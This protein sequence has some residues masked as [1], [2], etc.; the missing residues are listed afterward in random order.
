MR[1]RGLI[2]YFVVHQKLYRL[3]YMHHC[4]QF[5]LEPLAQ[6]YKDGGFH[7]TVEGV[8]EHFIPAVALVV[9]DAKEVSVIL[10]FSC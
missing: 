5:L 6:C 9:G 8:L 3:Q 7:M 4:I 10:A 2:L 1:G